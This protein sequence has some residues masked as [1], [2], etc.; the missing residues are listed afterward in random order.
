MS[1]K[2]IFIDVTQNFQL[3][4]VREDGKLVDFFDFVSKNDFYPYC[5]HLLAKVTRNIGKHGFLIN[6]PN[7]KTGFLSTRKKY[8]LG[9]MIIVRAKHFFDEDKLKVL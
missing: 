6:L 7:K 4:A 8:A 2:E 9:E 3:V 5:T 1:N